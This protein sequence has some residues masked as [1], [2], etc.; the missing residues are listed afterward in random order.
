M[1]Q[2]ISVNETQG[3]ILH[4]LQNST[5]HKNEYIIL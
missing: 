2:S 1:L 4:Y 5:I 3:K